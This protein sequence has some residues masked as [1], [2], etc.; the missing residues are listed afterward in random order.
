[1]GMMVG[2]YFMY[3]KALLTVGGICPQPIAASS[4]W[5]PFSTE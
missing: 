5:K 2:K 1:M 4:T 3:F